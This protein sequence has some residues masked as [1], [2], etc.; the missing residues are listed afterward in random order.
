M[1]TIPVDTKFLFKVLK[2]LEDI[3]TN[4]K[5]SDEIFGSD[6]GGLKKDVLELQTGTKIAINTVQVPNTSIPERI[7]MNLIKEKLDELNKLLN[8]FGKE[9]ERNLSMKKFRN[10]QEGEENA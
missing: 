3:E 8:E 2:K 6:I 9:Y 4:Q 1:K 10:R 7:R 5:V